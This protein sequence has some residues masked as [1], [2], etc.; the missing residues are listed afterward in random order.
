[1]II[2]YCRSTA[3]CIKVEGGIFVDTVD[4]VKNIELKIKILEENLA[5]K[6]RFE[7]KEKDNFKRTVTLIAEDLSELVSDDMLSVEFRE[8]MET[9][10][11]KQIVLIKKA[12]RDLERL[13]QVSKDII[14]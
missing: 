13:L 5:A 11:R 2:F 8:R 6:S 7:D 3:N 9:P 1:M 4:R 14:C 12:L 10:T